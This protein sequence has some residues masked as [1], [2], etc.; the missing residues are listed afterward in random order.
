MWRQHSTLSG[1]FSDP[2][3]LRRP[4][5]LQAALELARGLRRGL[6]SRRRRHRCLWGRTRPVL[7][8]G[9]RRGPRSR[10][11]QPSRAAPRWKVRSPRRHRGGPSR[12]RGPGPGASQ[13][14]RRCDRGHPGPLGGQTL[15]PPGSRQGDHPD[16]PLGLH[17]TRPASLPAEGPE[18][19]R[20][21]HRGNQAAPRTLLRSGDGRDQGLALLLG[22]AGEDARERDRRTRRPARTPGGATAPELLGLFGVGPDTAATLLVAA[23]DNPERLRSEAAWAHLCGVA[24]IQAS[25]GK[26]TIEIGPHGGG[27]RQANAA[28][29]RIVLVRI[30]HDPDTKAYLERR[31]KE[32]RSKL[33]VIR[34]LKRYVAREVIDIY[35]AADLDRGPGS[36]HNCRPL[37]AD[38][39]RIRR[40]TIKISLLRSV[41]AH[42]SLPSSDEWLFIVLPAVFAPRTTS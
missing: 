38:S 1:A 26:V 17:C 19:G 36:S 31:T 33:E 8:R 13:D 35:L 28:L 42:K 34:I 27:N 10:P 5:R 16:A 29:F 41:W 12:P 24:P 22:T 23:G 3:P 6:Q 20:S 18:R 40:P 15:G 25:S 32:G 21:R 14:P 7:A 11:A 9:G 39:H 4:R 37:W 2:G 30:A